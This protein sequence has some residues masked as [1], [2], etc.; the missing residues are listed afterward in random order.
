[1]NVYACICLYVYMYL[2]MFVCIQKIYLYIPKDLLLPSH[3]YR[4]SD[5]DT[6]KKEV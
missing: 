6:D 1:M 4:H 5:L 3:N 2:H